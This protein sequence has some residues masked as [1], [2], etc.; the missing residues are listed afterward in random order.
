MKVPRRLLSFAA[1][2]T[3]SF[4]I[5]KLTSPSGMTVSNWWDP[6]SCE[7]ILNLES[8]RYNPL[9]AKLV[10]PTVF[11]GEST[12]NM[13]PAVTAVSIKGEMCIML[14]SNQEVHYPDPPSIDTCVTTATCL[15][16]LLAVADGGGKIN[17]FN[18]D[19]GCI[20]TCYIDQGAVTEAATTLTLFRASDEYLLI[21]GCRDGL[22]RKYQV[23]WSLAHSRSTTSTPIC[24]RQL[25]VI[26]PPQWLKDVSTLRACSQGRLLITN[27]DSVCVI[28]IQNAQTFYKKRFIKHLQRAYI[29]EDSLYIVTSKGVE[30]VLLGHAL[31]QHRSDTSQ[32]DPPPDGSGDDDDIWGVLE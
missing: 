12:V 17:I 6:T 20:N 15:G 14:P 26:Q 7:H 21:A 16:P 27:D 23:P 8:P 4:L 25:S 19:A 18:Q 10:C 22:I 2:A 32:Q 3:S 28:S 24:L 30:E 9:Q 11:I 1:A 29:Q 5:K 31:R 13:R